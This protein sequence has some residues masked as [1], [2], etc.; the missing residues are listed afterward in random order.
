LLVAGCASLSHRV[1][2]P[3]SPS[4]AESIYLEQ[5]PPIAQRAYQCGPAA[6][7]SVLRYWEQPVDADELRQALI[8]PGARGVLNFALANY[9]RTRGVWTEVHQADQ[10]ALRTWLEQGIPPIVM[11]RVGPWGAPVYHFIVVRGLNDRDG[12]YYANVGDAAP[13]AIRYETFQRRWQDAGYWCLI[14]VPAER[15]DWD[16]TAA[17]AGELALL[18]EQTG[19]LE[20]AERWYRTALKDEPGNQA[21]RFNLANVHLRARNW[22]AATTIYREL[23]RESPQ[24]GQVSNNL[25]WIALEEG[26]PEETV[27]LIEQVFKAGAPRDY[28][29]L[30]T[31]GLA[32][33][34]LKQQE[35]GQAYFAEALQNTPGAR[36]DAVA[37]IQRHAEECAR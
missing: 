32:Y 21:L 27:R 15:V 30:D 2:P 36:F 22:D 7:E 33:C 37:L 5:L 18:L 17:Q 13:H 11:L 24:W 19:R 9:P 23:L 34:R 26:K 10:D 35:A 12:I 6:L 14:V 8:T 25:A 31:L 4:S 3:A 28:D 20:L 1:T 16:L 29:I